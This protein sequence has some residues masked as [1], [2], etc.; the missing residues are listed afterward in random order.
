MEK[1]DSEQGYECGLKILVLELIYFVR[2]LFNISIFS[3]NMRNTAS[4]K[5]SLP[6]QTPHFPPGHRID[7]RADPYIRFGLILRVLRSKT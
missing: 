4:T 1:E 6:T 3:T 2:L 7:E 5:H